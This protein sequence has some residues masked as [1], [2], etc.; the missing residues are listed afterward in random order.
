MVVFFPPPLG[1]RTA[2]T[3]PAGTSRESSFTACTLPNER[4][5]CSVRIIAVFIQSLLVILS[6]C[7]ACCSRASSLFNLLK[8]YREIVPVC[9]QQVEKRGCMEYKGDRGTDF[10]SYML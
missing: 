7:D 10:T 2:K 9:F 5:S 8:A 3:F 6:S 1:P 4:E